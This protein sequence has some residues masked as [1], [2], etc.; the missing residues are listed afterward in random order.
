MF[1]LGEKS[2]ANDFLM[3]EVRLELGY[4]N[5]DFICAKRFLVIELA[6]NS[7][8]FLSSQVKICKV[9]FCTQ[10]T[11]AVLLTFITIVTRMA[12]G[13]VSLEF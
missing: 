4:A 3:T 6:L 11:T 9:N 8:T 13:R 10:I 7:I 5:V 12:V 2:Q 1:F